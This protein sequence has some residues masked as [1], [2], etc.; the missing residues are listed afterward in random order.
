[1]IIK[2]VHGKSRKLVSLSVSLLFP[3]CLSCVLRIMTSLS[4]RRSTFCVVFI[5][6]PRVTIN[7]AVSIHVWFRRLLW[8]LWGS[9]ESI[10]VL[11]YSLLLITQAPTLLPN[12]MLLPVGTAFAVRVTMDLHPVLCPLATIGA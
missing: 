10:V 7:L 2:L 3:Y 5:S 6:A 11:P 8:L 9:E 1:M 12:V 4:F